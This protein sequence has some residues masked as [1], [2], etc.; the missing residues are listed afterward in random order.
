MKSSFVLMLS[1]GALCMLLP[2]RGYLDLKDVLERHFS[3][4]TNVYADYYG[5][6]QP[7]ADLENHDEWALEDLLVDQAD[8]TEAAL[9]C[10]KEVQQKAVAQPL[11]QWEMFEQFEEHFK[12]K[13]GAAVTKKI[14]KV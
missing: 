1:N 12:K 11:S 3:D 5:N 10:L 8:N 4:K 14:K 9:Q 6:E 7:F 13:A 2:K